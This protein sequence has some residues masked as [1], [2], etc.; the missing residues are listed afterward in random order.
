ME[1][2]R[3]K[4]EILTNYSEMTT[5]TNKDVYLCTEADARIKTLEDALS[6]YV[7]VCPQKI[8]KVTCCTNC[9]H[10][11]DCHALKALQGDK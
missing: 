1:L 10:Q 6:E 9:K 11:R 7:S 8:Q 5:E 3:Y 2:K 4:A